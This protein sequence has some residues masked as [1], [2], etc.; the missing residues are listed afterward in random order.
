MMPISKRG[1]PHLILLLATSLIGTA[2]YSAPKLSKAEAAVAAL[3]PE[4]VSD[5]VKVTGTDQLDPTLWVSTKPLLDHPGADKFLRAAIDKTSG[6]VSYQIYFQSASSRGPLRLSKL[7]YLI[8]GQLKASAITVIGTDVSCQRWGCIH[9]EDAIADL[10]R[11]DLE[12][13]SRGSTPEDDS[14]RMRLFGNAVEGGD[15][16]MF[17]NEIAGFLIA[18]DR[19]L[20][21]LHH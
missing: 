12:A 2:A 13:L 21:T 20:A 18:V 15:T 7:T 1:L 10:P 11:Q 4:Q 9:Y 17:R 5:R 19:Q 14:W 6:K 3:T 8:D 16:Q